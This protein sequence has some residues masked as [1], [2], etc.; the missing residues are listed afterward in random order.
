MLEADPEQRS[1]VLIDL[2]DVVA[3]QGRERHHDQLVA[4][5]C[6]QRSKLL[7]ER[8]LDVR[9]ND[10]RLVDDAAGERREGRVGGKS[11]KERQG[12]EQGEC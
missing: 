11:R 12:G 9:W 7:V 10:A 6:L 8:G 2:G 4:G 5:F 1:A 3:L